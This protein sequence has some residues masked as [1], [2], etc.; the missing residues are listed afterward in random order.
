MCVFSTK[1][2]EE[3]KY[4]LVGGKNDFVIDLVV[5]GWKNNGHTN[6]II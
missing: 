4:N 2:Y 3:W 5:S 6:M 1:S